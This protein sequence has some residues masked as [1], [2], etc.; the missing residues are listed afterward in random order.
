MW[1]HNPKKRPQISEVVRKLSRSV[2]NDRLS[3]FYNYFGSSAQFPE[4]I[5]SYPAPYSFPTQTPSTPPS[6][7]AP[8]S[9]TS[10]IPSASPYYGYTPPPPT[11]PSPKVQSSSPPDSSSYQYRG[12]YKPNMSAITTPPSPPTTSYH[13]SNKYATPT[14]EDNIVD[15]FSKL[16]TSV[17]LSSSPT[18]EI[19]QKL[20]LRFVDETSTESL[21]AAL[22][23]IKTEEGPDMIAWTIWAMQIYWTYA[24][25]K[26]EEIKELGKIRVLCLTPSF[27]QNFF[28]SSSFDRREQLLDLWHDLGQEPNTTPDV[29]LGFA[30]VSRHDG[31]SWPVFRYERFFHSSISVILVE[32]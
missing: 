25:R 28:R 21:R 13:H 1:A 23:S 27:L 32:N 7:S 11:S 19:I 8:S 22:Q 29:V 31:I 15:R 26:E 4:P 20:L 9:S 3:T 18:A 6:N 14:D 17:S 30:M 5:H 10:A 12:A 24:K 16:Q 2:R